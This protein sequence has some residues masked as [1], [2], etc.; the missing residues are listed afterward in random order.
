VLLHLGD[1]RAAIGHRDTQRRVDLGQ[2]A[3][4]E[5]GVDDDTLDFDEL[6]DDPAV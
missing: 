2:L 6:A 5:D 4:G 3:M 1:Q